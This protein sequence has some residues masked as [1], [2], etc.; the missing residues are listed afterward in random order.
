LTY[1]NNIKHEHAHEH[2]EHD[3]EHEHD[4]VLCRSAAPQE[5]E[6]EHFAA[7]DFDKTLEQKNLNCSDLDYTMCLSLSRSLNDTTTG[8]RSLSHM[9]LSSLSSSYVTA[10]SSGIDMFHDNNH[11]VIAAETTTEV[12]LSHPCAISGTS[13]DAITMTGPFTDRIIDKH[14]SIFFHYA[15]PVKIRLPTKLWSSESTP[16]LKHTA[17]SNAPSQ[18]SSYSQSPISSANEVKGTNSALFS[19]ETLGKTASTESETPKHPTYS[20]PSSLSPPCIRVMMEKLAV[21]T[22]ISRTWFPCTLKNGMRGIAARISLALFCP[23]VLSKDVGSDYQWW[24]WH[25][26]VSM[27]SGCACGVVLFKLSRLAFYM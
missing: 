26:P 14:L 27:M 12:S 4:N 19:D 2:E 10:P 20:A 23:H 7:S 9:S 16:E 13:H 21:K 8:P 1:A 5:P 24:Y 3:L 22:S 6:L 17:S 18:E 11:K 25:V 15:I